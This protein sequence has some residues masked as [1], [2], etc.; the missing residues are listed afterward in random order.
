M[1]N[2]PSPDSDPIFTPDRGARIAFTSRRN[3][4]PEIFYMRSTDGAYPVDVIQ[5]P[6]SDSMASWQPLVAAPSS[7]TPIQHVVVMYQENHSF[8]NVLGLWCVRHPPCDGATQG[9][10]SDG[11][12]VNLRKA[13][14]L[15]PEVTHNHKNQTTAVA[16]GQMNGW[17]LVQGCEPST[18]LQCMVQFRPTQIPNLWDMATTYAVSDR[19]FQLAFVPSWH[20]HVQLVASTLDGFDPKKFPFRGEDGLGPGWGC[21]S[22]RDDHWQP[23]VFDPMVNEPACI[24]QMDG[25]GPYRESQVSWVPTI[26]DRF[27]EAGLAWHIYAPPSDEALGYGFSTCPTFA[28]CLYGPQHNNVFAPEQFAVDAAAGNLPNFSLLIPQAEN[29]QHNHYSML[30]GDNWLGAS[31]D[32]IMS[33]PDWDSTAIFILYDDCGCF[34]DHAAPPPNLGMRVPMVIVS[35]YT[36]PGFVDSNV[37]SFASMLAFTEHT[38]GLAPL[39]LTDAVA[40]DY[41]GTF[42]YSQ[43]PLS[44]IA[45]SQHP[46]PK[47][48]VK[49]LKDH[50]I[51]SEEEE[52][53]PYYTLVDA[54]GDG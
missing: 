17:D 11:T 6:A 43:Q 25:S 42:N 49:W 34:Y 33:G 13:T 41:A 45:L 1:T 19:T 12:L 5:N 35:P 37:A 22:F 8:D 4:N 15:V 44:P 47:W 3:G 51:T 27:D 52:H 30:Q 39:G 21:D 7:P 10:I 46:L 31:V 18:N 2:D 50:P 23:T 40:Y 32:A 20:S 36:K 9:E 16:G 26:M 28:E 48:E 53:D 29:S 54:A 14:D 38:F 24:P